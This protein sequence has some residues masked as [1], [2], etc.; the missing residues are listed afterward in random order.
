MTPETNGNKNPLK[1]EGYYQHAKGGAVVWVESTPGLGT[2]LIDAYVSA[3]YVY[4]GKEDPT[5]KAEV[6]ESPK[7]AKK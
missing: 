3:G 7:E 5:A 6:V 4:V 2:P 1:P